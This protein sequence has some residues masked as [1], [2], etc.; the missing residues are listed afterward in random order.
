MSDISNYYELVKKNGN[1]RTTDHAK[2]W[3]RAVLQT[4]GLNLP[5]SAKKTLS[6]ALPKE[7]SNDLSDVWWLI[8]FRNTDMSLAEFQERVGRRAGNTDIRF[9]RIP[10]KAV[11]GALQTVVGSNVAKEVGDSLAPELKTL[12]MSAA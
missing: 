5:R 2:R 3:S 11:F 4:L 8:H 9:A 1:L 7:L 6:N 12:W 10:T